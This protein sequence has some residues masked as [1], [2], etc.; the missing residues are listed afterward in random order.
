MILFIIMGMLFLVGIPVA[1]SIGIAMPT[2]K[3]MPIMINRIIYC[4]PCYHSKTD[5]CRC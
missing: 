5:S 4:S 1:F 3:S 2:K